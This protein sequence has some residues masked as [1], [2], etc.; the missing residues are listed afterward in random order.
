M[1][2][3]IIFDATKALKGKIPSSCEECPF[4]TCF[5]GVDEWGYPELIDYYCFLADSCR[6]PETE[7]VNE[8]II[9]EETMGTKRLDV[10]PLKMNMEKC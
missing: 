8:T 5:E 9:D 4:K 3:K 6:D 7:D 1:E 2:F 10:C